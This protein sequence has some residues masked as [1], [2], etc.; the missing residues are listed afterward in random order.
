MMRHYSIYDHVFERLFLDCI[1][2]SRYEDLKLK[3]FCFICFV[4]SSYRVIDKW[5]ISQITFLVIVASLELTFLNDASS[6]FARG[7]TS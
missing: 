2:L 4:N 3:F 7:V 6:R 1:I 5:C